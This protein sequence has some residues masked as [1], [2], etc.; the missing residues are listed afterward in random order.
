[1]RTEKSKWRGRTINEPQRPKIQRVHPVGRMAEHVRISEKRSPDFSTIQRPATSINETSHTKLHT[2]CFV[3]VHGTA[4]PR[5]HAFNN[6]HGCSEF[7]LPK[8]FCYPVPTSVFSYRCILLISKRLGA[9]DDSVNLFECG[10]SLI[11]P[12]VAITAAHCIQPCV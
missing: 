1:M 5:N 2:K 9:N 3:G 8:I 6:F 10:A 4:A 11:A 7:R 12:G